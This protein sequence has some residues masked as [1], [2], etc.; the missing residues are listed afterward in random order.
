MFAAG[1]EAKS[2]D[3]ML[4]RWISWARRCHL[5]PFKRLGATS[6]KHLAGIVEHFLSGLDNGFDEA[7]NGRVQA[8]KVRAKGYGTDAHLITMS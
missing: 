5:A 4:T 8:C 1:T 3:T 7:I 6:R 2:G